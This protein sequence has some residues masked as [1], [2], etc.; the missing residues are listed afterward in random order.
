MSDVNTINLIAL[1]G[2]EFDWINNVT[3]G[4]VNYCMPLLW[5]TL[6]RAD[7]IQDIQFDGENGVERRYY[8]VVSIKRA[9]DLMETTV[10]HFNKL[11]NQGALE[12]HA[13]FLKSILLSCE[14]ENVAITWNCLWGNRHDEQF[15]K[16]ILNAATFLDYIVNE[17]DQDK[18]SEVQSQKSFLSNLKNKV[19]DVIKD[20]FTE[21]DE[22]DMTNLQAG[23]NLLY[24]LAMF[25]DQTSFIALDT[26]AEKSSCT[27]EDREM[28]KSIFGRCVHI[29]DVLPGGRDIIP[30]KIVADPHYRR[31][32]KK[33]DG[34][35]ALEEERRRKKMQS[36][37]ESTIEGECLVEFGVF[38][39]DEYGLPK[40]ILDDV[41][42]TGRVY[43]VGEYDPDFVGDQNFVGHDYKSQ[44]VEDPTWLTVALFANQMMQTTGN[45][46][47]YFLGDIAEASMETDDPNVK[48]YEF[49]MES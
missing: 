7:D 24:K 37:V 31:P 46:D 25:N 2:T 12:S 9:V 23:K 45:H 19:S 14:K 27:P 15:K 17:F 33:F 28:L 26:L 43:F 38:I 11:F 5:M 10:P 36:L 13:K 3:L 41:A 34:D 8:P 18:P 47:H 44:I 32:T 16:Q 1:D 4:G 48:C 35:E 30:G 42:V 29:E 40:E 49:V 39:E 20:V 6:Y 22:N 21:V